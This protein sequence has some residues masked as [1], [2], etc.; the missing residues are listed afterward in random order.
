MNCE[1]IELPKILGKVPCRGSTG[2]YAAVSDRNHWC[3]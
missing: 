1:T 3:V 2:S